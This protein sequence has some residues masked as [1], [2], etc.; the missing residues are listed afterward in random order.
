MTKDRWEDNFNLKLILLF[1]AP[2]PGPI[3]GLGFLLNFGQ[4]GFAPRPTIGLFPSFVS[5]TTSTKIQWICR[6]IGIGRI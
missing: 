4:F 2:F 5:S 1:K 6:W 3:V